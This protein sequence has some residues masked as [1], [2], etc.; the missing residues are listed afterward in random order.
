MMYKSALSE[1]GDESYKGCTICNNIKEMIN[2]CQVLLLVLLA[3]SAVFISSCSRVGV[4][5]DYLPYT[6][7]IKR[8]AISPAFVVDQSNVSLD[9]PF[10]YNIYHTPMGQEFVPTL[11]AIDAIELNIA[12]ASCNNNGAGDGG[13]LRLRIRE[14]KIT[15]KI[16]GESDIIHFDNCFSG[17]KRFDFP[18]FVGVN[19]GQKYVIELVYV[20]GNSSLFYMDNG[21]YPNYNAGGFI[22]NGKIEKGMDM[23]FK[24]GLYHSIARTLQQ[25]E[26]DGWKKIVRN[27]GT[28]FKSYQDCVNYISK[29]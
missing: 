25:A 2:K 8:N 19:P 15:G 27:D 29:L 7:Q 3:V 23:W 1:W 20:S 26:N 11:H 4:E 13:E 12:D 9:K 18:A 6:N 16:L 10:Y 22:L 5:V 24:E 28:T 14:A 21:P 17:I